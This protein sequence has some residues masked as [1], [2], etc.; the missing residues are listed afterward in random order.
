MWKAETEEEKERNNQRN[1]ARVRRQPKLGKFIMDVLYDQANNEGD[2]WHARIDEHF[3]KVS[4][5]GLD[6]DLAGPWNRAVE[7][8]ERWVTEEGNDRIKRELE[9]LKTHVARLWEENRAQMLP[10][11]RK[12]VKNSP[13]RGKSASFTELPIEVRQDKFRILSKAFTSFPRPNQFIMADE[14]VARI[15]ASYA[16]V[17]DVDKKKSSGTNNFTRFPWNVGMRELCAIKARATGRHK[18][19]SGDFYDHFNMKHPKKHHF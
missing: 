6:E 10:T 12:Q 1:E 8:G 3:S 11:P 2:K 5:N 16:Y 15:R 18:T 17:Y 13:T 19:V 9:S 14:E 4:R 7:L